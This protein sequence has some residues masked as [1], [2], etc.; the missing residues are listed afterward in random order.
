MRKIVET[1]AA[2]R[3][4]DLE[5]TQEGCK[6]RGERGSVLKNVWKVLLFG[7]STASRITERTWHAPESNSLWTCG[8]E[9]VRGRQ[10]C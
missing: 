10:G 2:A 9:G 1:E 6:G 3:V 7:M 4:K 8:F 5:E